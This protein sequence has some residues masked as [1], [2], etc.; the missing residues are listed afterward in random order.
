MC[1]SNKL[2]LARL[3]HNTHPTFLLLLLPPNQLVLSSCLVLSS[4]VGCHKRCTCATP[5]AISL[6]SLRQQSMS[7]R[8]RGPTISTTMPV[9]WVTSAIVV[10]VIFIGE[11]CFL[12]GRGTNGKVGITRKV[13]SRPDDLAHLINAKL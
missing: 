9:G 8:R 12:R 11:V 7:W 1:S 2:Y 5:H 3:K 10:V 4:P 6:A 13:F